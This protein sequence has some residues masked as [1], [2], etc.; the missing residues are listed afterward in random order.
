MLGEAIRASG[1]PREEFR[2]AIKTD[3]SSGYQG[4]IESIE[5][6]LKELDLGS[7]DLLMMEY[8]EIENLP[9]DD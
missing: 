6:S 2:V 3:F 4:T 7:I 1:I 8:E 9:D 5:K